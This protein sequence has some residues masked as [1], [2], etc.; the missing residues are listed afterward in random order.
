[1]LA[2]KNKLHLTTPY[3]RFRV[4][5]SDCELEVTP[6]L[7]YFLALDINYENRTQS[8]QVR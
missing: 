3:E 1:M 2:M 5:T 4:V 6:G 7:K 8:V